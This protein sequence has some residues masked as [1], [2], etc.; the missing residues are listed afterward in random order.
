MHKWL[1]LWQVVGLIVI[2]CVSSVLGTGPFVGILFGQTYVL[3]AVAV[4]ICITFAM[5]VA[6]FFQLHLTYL[7]FFPFKEAVRPT[8]SFNT[9]T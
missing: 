5:L 2:A 6:L 8:A 9:P 4:C 3:V 7:D 1:L